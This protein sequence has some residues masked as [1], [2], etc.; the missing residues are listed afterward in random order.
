MPATRCSHATQKKETCPRINDRS[1]WNSE[2]LIYE[3]YDN[4]CLQEAL[5]RHLSD[6][7]DGVGGKTTVVEGVPVLL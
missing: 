6:G 3:L 5:R 7:L 4:T 1:V 2:T